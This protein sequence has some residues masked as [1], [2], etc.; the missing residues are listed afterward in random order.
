[1]I[2]KKYFQQMRPRVKVQV[3]VVPVTE[4]MFVEQLVGHAVFAAEAVACRLRDREVAD[5]V[6]ADIGSRDAVDD[7]VALFESDDGRAFTGDDAGRLVHV[8]VVGGETLG[9]D[10]A[11]GVQDCCPVIGVQGIGGKVQWWRWG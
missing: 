8:E 2:G 4:D 10:F 1:M 6:D 9:G 5:P 11:C 3:E 7:A